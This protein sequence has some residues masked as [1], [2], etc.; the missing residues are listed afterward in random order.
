MGSSLFGRNLDFWSSA[1]EKLEAI[2]DERIRKTLEVSY[3]ALHDDH[4][5]RLFLM[6]AWCYVGEDMDD[7]VKKLEEQDFYSKIGMENLVDRSLISVDKDNKLVMHHLIRDMAR[8]I[9]RQDTIDSSWKQNSHISTET[10]ETVTSEGS[11][12]CKNDRCGK[13]KRLEDYEDESMPP[14]GGQSNLFKRL[15]LGFLSLF[16][17]ATRLTKLLRRPHR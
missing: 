13:R 14:V 9:I 3:K 10:T 2:P 16:E 4:D 17:P 8:A 7:V 11:L 5:K 1:L 15:C 12:V 6:I